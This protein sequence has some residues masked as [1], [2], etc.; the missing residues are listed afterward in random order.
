MYGNSAS[1]KREALLA[2]LRA[3]KRGA[4][5]EGVLRT[6]EQPNDYNHEMP[7]VTVELEGKGTTISRQT[8]RNGLYRFTGIARERISSRQNCLAISRV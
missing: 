4:T 2:E 8:T 5:V 7:D 1:G 3:R 6:K